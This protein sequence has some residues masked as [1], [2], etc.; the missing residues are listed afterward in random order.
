[1]AHSDPQRLALPDAICRILGGIGVERDRALLEVCEDVLTS[2]GE[3]YA[4]PPWRDPV[5]EPFRFTPRELLAARLADNAG[6]A[7][8]FGEWRDL[9]LTYEGQCAR[10]LEVLR[11]TAR[12]L[13]RLREQAPDPPGFDAG[14]DQLF[15][16]VLDAWGCD[17]DVGPSRDWTQRQTRRFD[18]LARELRDI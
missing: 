15:G 9:V 6:L 7:R 14:L 1:M 12:T 8:L 10:R 16:F 5:P 18:L 2:L 3:H 4:R 17:L 11:S 13:L